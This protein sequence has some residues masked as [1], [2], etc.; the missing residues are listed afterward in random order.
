[1]DLINEYI[2]ICNILEV[3]I[4]NKTADKIANEIANEL[5]VT[6]HDEINIQLVPC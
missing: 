4:K 6:K 2:E 5:I 1:M 3:I